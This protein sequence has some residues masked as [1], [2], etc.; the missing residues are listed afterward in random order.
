MKR[1]CP[2]CQHELKGK[3]TA[4]LNNYRTKVP[5]FS[6][7]CKQCGTRIQPDPFYWRMQWS[8]TFLMLFV[9]T[10]VLYV[11]Q[12]FRLYGKLHMTA[13]VWSVWPT[14]GF[15]FVLM[16]WG[17]IKMKFVV[18]PAEGYHGLTLLERA[19]ITLFILWF[20][21]QMVVLA[22]GIIE[23]DDEQAPPAAKRLR[24]QWPSQIQDSPK[25]KR[26]TEKSFVGFRVQDEIPYPVG[27]LEEDQRM[28]GSIRA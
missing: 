21:L 11:A 27:P 13:M 4:P 3:F 16:L 10:A 15:G 5:L 25:D 8:G 1:E 17:M 22:A 18:S 7:K 28:R 23:G 9:A 12:F 24:K 20:S 14:F 26:T 6:S 2:V 19:G